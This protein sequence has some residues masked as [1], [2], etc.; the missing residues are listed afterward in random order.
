M[1]LTNIILDIYK[2]CCSRFCIWSPS[3][4]VDQTWE[5]VKDYIRDH[6]KYYFDAYDTSE[7]E[8]I[9]DTQQKVINYQKRKT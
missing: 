9:I 6:R 3:I 7:L 2:G 4:E 5:A 1:L 8:Q